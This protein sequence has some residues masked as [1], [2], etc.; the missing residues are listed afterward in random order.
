LVVGLVVMAGCRRDH[1]SPVV[2]LYQEAGGGDVTQSTPDG[3]A[4]FL[5]KHEEL[6]KRLTPLCQQQLLSAESW[7]ANEAGKVCDGNTRANFF[8]KTKVKSDGVAF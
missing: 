6:R 8:G 2:R 1:E 7:S 4:Q 3:I 5:A